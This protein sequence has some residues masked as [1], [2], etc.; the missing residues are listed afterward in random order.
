LTGAN[1]LRWCRPG[2]FGFLGDLWH[3]LPWGLCGKTCL[4]L[5]GMWHATKFD[6]VLTV[7]CVQV[8]N[9]L[10]QPPEYFTSEVGK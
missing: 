2:A 5:G 3:R 10:S 8:R 6:F 9:R 7:P 1:A 4:G